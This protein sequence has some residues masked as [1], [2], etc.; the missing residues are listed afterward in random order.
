[1]VALVVVAS[2]WIIVTYV[3]AALGVARRSER[4]TGVGPAIRARLLRV[5]DGGLDLLRAA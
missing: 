4:K 2:V 1:L 5:R 3:D